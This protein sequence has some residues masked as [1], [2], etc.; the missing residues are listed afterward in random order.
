M[1]EALIAFLDS[2][3]YESALRLSLSLGG[4]ADTMGS[5]TG[6][7][8]EA[9]YGHVPQEMIEKARALLPADLLQVV[10]KFVALHVRR[11]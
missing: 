2:T 8:A 11:S 5:I 6:A 9:F 4:D 3:D 1:P 7:V 10:E